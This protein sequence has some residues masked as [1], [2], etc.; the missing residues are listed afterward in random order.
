MR[1]IGSVSERR[2]ARVKEEEDRENIG[3]GISI[4]VKER[5]RGGE[6]IKEDHGGG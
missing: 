1:K 6:G 4:H 3:V 2:S 5:N